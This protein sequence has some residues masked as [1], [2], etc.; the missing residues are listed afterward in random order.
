VQAYTFEFESAATTEQRFANR[1]KIRPVKFVH[2]FPEFPEFPF[3]K[4]L[5]QGV[6]VARR[7]RSHSVKP[8]CRRH[9]RVTILT[10]TCRRAG[11]DILPARK[12]NYVRRTGDV[13]RRAR[14][15]I[16]VINCTTKRA[17]F[18]P[19][20][21]PSAPAIA[22]LRFVRSADRQSALACSRAHTCSERERE[23]GGT[24]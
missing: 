21:C 24:R 7:P 18:H 15:L 9:E 5:S 2:S 17:R 3:R 19:S 8:I 4:S 23:G 11:G 13:Y 16:S 1:T 20:S 10:C 22:D 14:S 12:F 6:A